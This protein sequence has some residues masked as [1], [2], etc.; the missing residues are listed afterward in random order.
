MKILL[1]FD[2]NTEFISGV[3]QSVIHLS[4]GLSDLGHDVRLLMPSKDGKTAIEEKAFLAPSI[5]FDT[6]YPGLRIA[7]PLPKRLR[8][9]LLEWKPDII[10]TNTEASLYLEANRIA[11]KSGA[12]RVHTIHTNYLEYYTQ[13]FPF[14]KRLSRALM[15]AYGRL[16]TRRLD[17]LI[18]P[19]EWGRSNIMQLC[20]S[21]PYFILPNGI[22]TK[23][24]GADH[25]TERAQIRQ[26]Y[27]IQE[28]DTLL[29]FV[30]RIAGEKNLPQLFA[31]FG[32]IRDR[33]VKLMIVGGGP[34]LE[35]LK[36][37]TE[38][39]TGKERIIFTGMVPPEKTCEYYSA[40]DVF[41]T[42]SLSET[43]P[44]TY[45][46]AMASG[47]PVVCSYAPY[48]DGL[49][50]DGET[51][52]GIRDAGEFAQ[53]IEFLASNPRLRRTMGETARLR[54]RDEFSVASFAGN[55]LRIYTE[56]VAGA[57]DETDN[58]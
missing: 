23:L 17:G 27:G 54:V 3:S 12:R 51:G 33:R 19:S 5:C 57:K 14:G 29:T 21:G 13:Y 20:Y 11:R 22:P 38:A 4:K 28:E 34:V 8:K 58:N 56:I 31:Y 16:C 44:L 18:T 42:A 32:H 35:A 30:G 10:H 24:F 43:Q 36:K 47:L 7:F 49:V 39:T 53:R 26:R 45:L 37:Q 6:F 41:V 48:I 9:A 25:S 55:C 52:F 46:E 15:I 1:V 50:I 40:A 2:C